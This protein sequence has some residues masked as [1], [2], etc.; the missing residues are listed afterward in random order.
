MRPLSI[1]ISKLSLYVENRQLAK[2]FEDLSVPPATRRSLEDSLQVD[3]I[4][5]SCPSKTGCGIRIG[6]F[7]RVIS[8]ACSGDLQAI[9]LEHNLSIHNTLALTNPRR[10]G[11][12]AHIADFHIYNEVLDCAGNKKLVAKNEKEVLVLARETV[13]GSNRQQLQ[14]TVKSSRVNVVLGK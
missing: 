8:D 10:G 4:E 12:I 11:S 7:H 13:R 6:C 1:D 14:C 3:E 2:R 5:I 9:E